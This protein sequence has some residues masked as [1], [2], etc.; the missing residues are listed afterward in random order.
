MNE[1]LFIVFDGNWDLNDV[2][3]YSSLD[4]VFI[5]KSPISSS[6]PFLSS[7]YFISILERDGYIL[8]R[9]SDGVGWILLHLGLDLGSLDFRNTMSSMLARNL[10]VLF[11]T[12]LREVKLKELGI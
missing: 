6:H 7:T 3:L 8:N 11:K 9:G 2:N 1:F 12:A 5:G 4:D 10:M